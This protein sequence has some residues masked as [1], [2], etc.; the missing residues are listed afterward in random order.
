MLKKIPIRYSSLYILYRLVVTF[1]IFVM[2]TGCAGA[3]SIPGLVPSL[4]FTPALTETPVP[5]VTPTPTQTQLPPVG[6]LIVP[7]QADPRLAADLQQVLGE[8]IPAAGLRFQVRPSLSLNDLDRDRFRWI[9]ALAGTENLEALIEAAPEADFLAIGVEGMQPASNLTTIGGEV[10]RYDQQ[11]FI[12]GYIA[13]LIT[14]DWRVG[15]LGLAGLPEGETAWQG[16]ITGVRYYCGLCL[17]TYPPFYEYPLYV[18]L[19][20][21]ST[22]DEWQSAANT[23][24]NQSVETV[25]VMPGVADESLFR[26]LAQ[27]GMNILAGRTPP[28]QPLIQEHW[29]ASLRSDPFE[30]FVNY[31]PDF[32]AGEVGLSLPVPLT[33]TDVNAS[34]LSPGRERMA[35]EVLVDVMDGYVDP[36]QEVP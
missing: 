2:A 29:V 12:A 30:A 13:A 22:P 35:A 1:L 14:P 36:V 21:G 23:L 26:H 7:P 34:L 11:G 4:T 6:V 33:I 8:Q 16:F 18:G 27:S 17:Q 28:E 9:I 10:L 31:W 19:P 5:S 15:M 24:I 25:Y 3:P 20:S 32:M